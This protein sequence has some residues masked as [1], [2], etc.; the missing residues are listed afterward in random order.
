MKKLKT[1]LFCSLLVF[2][3]LQD[4]VSVDSLSIT[5]GKWNRNESHSKGT[6]IVKSFCPV[7]KEKLS[8]VA[9]FVTTKTEK[10]VLTLNLPP[11]RKVV[12]TI[13]NNFSK[14]QVFHDTIKVGQGQNYATLTATNGL[15]AALNAGTMSNNT[16][17][18]ITSD[19]TEPGPTKL[20]LI[21]ESGPNAGSLSLIIKSDGNSHVISGTALGATSPLIYINGAKRLKIDGG[22]GKKLTFRNT[23]TNSANTGPTI[24]FNSSAQ[25][26]TVTNCIIENNST[27]SNNGA[28]RI[29]DIGQNIV[30]ISNCDIRDARGGTT[31]S[32]TVGIYS[33]SERN[34]LNINNNNIYNLKNVD[35]YGILLSYID[36]GCIITGNSIYMEDG[37]IATG[38]FTGIKLGTNNNHLVSGNYIG[39]SAPNCGGLP[40]TFSGSAIFTGIN[41][42]SYGT[43]AGN[44]EGN[45]IQNIV[46]TNSSTPKFYGIFY[47]RGPI[48]ISGNTVGSATV[49]NSIR[50][51]GT[52]ESA[53]IIKNYY[54]SNYSCTIDKNTIAN[55]SLTNAT[56][57]PTFNG[58]KMEGGTARMNKIFNI[59][60]TF[61]A[62]S[63]LIYGIYNENG[64]SLNE[65]S[66]NVISLNGGV[67]SNP[68]LYGIYDA[69]KL[70]TSYFYY[71]SIYLYGIASGSS[72]TFAFNRSYI[73]ANVLSNNI[74]F[75][76]RTGGTGI[77][78]AISSTNTSNFTS[79]YNDLYVTGTTL[80]HFGAAGSVN[81]KANITAW[82]STSQD[83]NSINFDPL[84][85]G[86][87][88]L[89][90][91]ETSPV[92][93]HGTPVPGI[94]TDISNTLRSIFSPTIG[95]YEI[96]C[97]N[98]INGGTI[99]ADQ[100]VWNIT[101]DLLSNI[102]SPS[103][104]S[105]TLEYKWQSS[106][107]PFSLWS[108]IPTSNAS[109]FQTG[110]INETTK[111]KRLARTTC[112]STWLSAA[113]SNIVT[114][115]ISKNKWRGSVSNNYNDPANWTHNI[116]PP[117][118]EDIIFDSTVQN[119]CRLNSN[120]SVNNITNNQSLFHIIT[121]GN[122]LSI[123][124]I[125]SGNQTPLVDVSTENSGITFIGDEAQIIPSGFFVNSNVYNMT[126][127]N[128]KGVTLST[129]LTVTNL[130]SIN[131]GK[132]LII[133]TDKLL[134]VT[135]TVNNKAGTTGLIIKASSDGSTPNGSIIFHNCISAECYVPATVEMFTKASD[136]NGSY[137]W[138]FFGIP[139]K[140][141]NA[142]PAFNG[143]YIREMHE[144]I[145]GTLGHWTKLQN[146]SV[147][148]SFTGY[149]ITQE[150]SKII[151]FEG[152]L[153]NADYGPVLLSY[154]PEATYKG[155]HLIGNPYTAAI[156]IKNTENSTNSL[157]FGE[158][159]D[160]TVYLYNTGSKEDWSGNG[161]YG[162]GDSNSAGQ[163]LAI[164]QEHAGIDQLPSSIPSMQA[165]LVMVNTPGTNAT[166]SIPYS[167]VGTVVK[168]TTIQRAQATEKNYTRIEVNGINSG[169][170]MWIFI[171]PTCTRGFDNGWDGYKLSGSIMSPQ[172]YAVETDGYY[173]VNSIE[174]LT[175][176]I[177][178]F[179]AGIDTTYT[180]T[181]THQNM[182]NLYRD[183]YLTDLYEKKTLEITNSGS[184]YT[185]N[186]TSGK[187]N[188]NR[189][190]INAIPNEPNII[191]GLE[192]NIN[193][194]E[195]IIIFNS[196]NDIVVNNNSNM[197]GNLYIYDTTGKYLQKLR[198][199]ASSIS[200]LPVNLPNGI[201]I[202]KVITIAEEFTKYLIFRE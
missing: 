200:T 70:Y 171:E 143:S 19:I 49:T 122:I 80:G 156:N 98:P 15:F 10:R 202:I 39:G 14:A 24:H 56:G 32:P 18:I 78:Y 161:S 11:N 30:T 136:V 35:S 17:V 126:I 107:F 85:T 6:A 1:I 33:Y 66:N 60:S 125:L 163:Y 133:S 21:N 57:T 12:T 188:D 110:M 100:E 31:G 117:A 119:D 61:A 41:S 58:L 116:V 111:Y 137:K 91:L 182:S 132:K 5:K 8:N 69:N 199:N 89:L 23:N 68:S 158:G 180:L 165:F 146:E 183:I 13:T 179:T 168:N 135:G 93:G 47:D 26:D 103:G 40:F 42:Y 27:M 192:S 28:I 154:T 166:I 44:I 82:R 181:F 189:F 174:D 76:S 128:S 193:N 67:S 45:T 160:R 73:G 138:Q 198:F 2:F 106:V 46:L 196:R 124:G 157:I 134:N 52:G 64:N 164:P 87:T 79:D 177:L 141:I 142:F 83:G 104:Y 22:V 108:D 145:T 54:S 55:I 86:Q 53:G 96:V 72:N 152:Y 4:L 105:G 102:A 88:N 99:A 118:N 97:F 149:E 63:P 153:E 186:S 75:N 150:S 3:N 184:Q 25:N 159:M 144:N 169:D 185:F 84:F 173:Q 147:L 114:I 170:R 16:V 29:F 95:A 123:K 201:Y 113:E 121:N 175:N 178:G 155:Q 92:Q 191:T 176:T 9:L 167:S 139:V 71:N 130:L 109:T 120:L 34:K 195:P 90:P 148:T 101:P 197:S 7:L 151:C 50:I 115:T 140:S 43:P 94:T 127:D 194:K 190:E 81:D 36:N 172:L 62:L 129:D 38:P 131:F 51:A 37:Y 74:I 48:T 112:M 77:H 162:V 59:G 65:F 20:N 187:V